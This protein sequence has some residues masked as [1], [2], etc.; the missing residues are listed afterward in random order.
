MAIA[1]RPRLITLAALCALLAGCAAPPR[2]EPQMAPAHPVAPAD[3]WR[4]VPITPFGTLLQDVH[5]PLHEVL[6]FG[7][8]RHEE[9]YALDAPAGS[10]I[11]RAPDSYLLCYSSGRLDRVEVSVS[12]PAAGAEAEFSR[13]CDQWQRG[14]VAL[15]PRTARSCSATGTQGLSFSAS[16]GEFPDDARDG[17]ALVVLAIVVFTDWQR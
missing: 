15:L 7:E 10:F 12:V 2:R 13:Y 16:L 9:C 5:V 8:L 3:D 17:E 6:M 1:P 4:S 11:G 14:S